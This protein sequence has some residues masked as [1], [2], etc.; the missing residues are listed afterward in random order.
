MSKDATS[1]KNNL[2][3]NDKFDVVILGYID[4]NENLFVKTFPIILNTSGVRHKY[5]NRYDL[6]I[7]EQISFPKDFI[8]TYNPEFL[9]SF[10]NIDILILTYNSSGFKPVSPFLRA[11]ISEAQ[12]AVLFLM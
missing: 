1:E 8:N 5:L 2:K 3:K 7:R 4:K 11:F 10:M 12:S 9:D 6:S